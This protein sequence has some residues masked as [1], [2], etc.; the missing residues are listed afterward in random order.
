M[1]S[2]EQLA[3]GWQEFS[4]FFCR[5]GARVFQSAYSFIALGR[6]NLVGLFDLILYSQSKVTGKEAEEEEREFLI[7]KHNY[8]RSFF[9]NPFL[10]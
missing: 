9:P 4:A 7:F 10:S 5:W 8:Q 1:Q 6:G 3:D 2:I